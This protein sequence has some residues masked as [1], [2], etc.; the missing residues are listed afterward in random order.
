[1]FPEGDR[2][3]SADGVRQQTLRVVD[4]GVEN[5][6]KCTK[7]GELMQGSVSERKRMNSYSSREEPRRRRLTTLFFFF[8]A[9][10]R[11][12]EAAVGFV[13]R[14]RGRMRSAFWS[15]STKR[16]TARHRF[17]HW[18]RDSCTWSRRTPSESMRPFSADRT[19]IFWSS[20]SDGEAATS[21]RSSTRVASLFTFC[22][23]GPPLR[24][25]E[26]CSS[27]SGM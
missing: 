21:N 18:L 26:K 23:P 5:N 10:L 14:R 19:S 4:S 25:N 6:V 8:A 12:R 2:R 3:Q 15:R 20:L 7:R 24:E 17:C 9:Y 27:A 22:P 13:R 1:M 16:S 11:S